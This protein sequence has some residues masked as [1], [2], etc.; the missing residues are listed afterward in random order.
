MDFTREQ[1]Q[2]IET[3]GTDILVAA[4]AG[5][6]KTRVLVNRIA[7]VVLDRDEPRDID[8]LLVVTFTR[9][10]ADEMRSRLYKLLDDKLS[11]SKDP[12]KIARIYDQQV[13]LQRSWI[14]TVHGFCKRVL[15]EN[16]AESGIDASYAV[17]DPALNDELIAQAIRDAAERFSEE[18][19]DRYKELVDIYGSFSSDEFL[20][21]YINK[22][23]TLSLSFPDPDK[24]L[25]DCLEK[26]RYPF[27]EGDFARTAYGKWLIEIIRLKLKVY[28]DELEKLHDLS[29]RYEIGNCI[30]T[31]DEDIPIMERLIEKVGRDGIT[32]HELF[33]ACSDV[34]FPRKYGATKEE[35]ENRDEYS[36]E[37]DKKIGNNRKNV[38][39]AVK[40]DIIGKLFSGSPDVPELDRLAVRDSMEAFV[41]IVR[42]ASELFARAKAE[43]HLYDYG[44]MEHM[45]LNILT[46]SAGGP[47][48]LALSY[49]KKFTEIYVDEYQDTSMIQEQILK[50][51][52]GD[53]DNGPNMFMVGDV[54]QSIYGFNNARPDLFLSKY[55]SFRNVDDPLSKNG[56]DEGVLVRL[57]KN[58]RSRNHV[59]DSVNMIFSKLMNEAT[60]GMPYGK[61]ECLD[62]GAD[63]PEQEKKEKTEIVV[64]EPADR[65]GIKVDNIVLE[66]YEILGRIKEMIARGDTVYDRDSKKARPVRYSDIC[67][68]MR[69]NKFTGKLADLLR[70]GGVPVKDTKDGSGLFVHPEIRTI[71]SFMQ[72]IDNPL[73]DIPLAAVL[74]NIYGFTGNMFVRIKLAVPGNDISLYR[75][76]Q[77]FAE[78]TDAGETR[79]LA[80]AFV[81]RLG[82]F[83]ERSAVRPVTETLRECMAENGFIDMI[84]S[85]KDGGV[86]YSNLMRL[87]SITSGFDDSGGGAFSDYILMLDTAANSGKTSSATPPESDAVSICTIHKSKGLEYPVVIIA[88]AGTGRNKKDEQVRLT[89]HR[90]L[91]FG[92]SCYVNSSRSVYCSIMNEAIRLRT[93]K[94]SRAEEMRLLYVA[95]TRAKEKLIITGV[96]KE[97]NKFKDDCYKKLDSTGKKPMDYHV[98]EADDFLT[99]LGMAVLCADGKEKESVSL[100]PGKYA[101]EYYESLI[102]AEGVTDGEESSGSE[103]EQTMGPRFGL[104]APKL[105]DAV[106]AE[107]MDAVKSKA[108]CPAK[109]SVSELKRLYEAK[110]GSGDDID[111]R[112]TVKVYENERFRLLEDIDRGGKSVSDAGGSALA[113]T[114]LH[115]C[116]EHADFGKIREIN[117]DAEKAAG[118]AAELRDELID[119]GFFSAEDGKLVS[120]DVLGKF[121]CSDFAREIGGSQEILREIPFAVSY[122][123]SELF[124]DQALEGNTTVVQGIIDCVCRTGG[125]VTLIDYKSDAVRGG[126]GGNA[127]LEEH[128]KRYAVQ[129]S[130]YSEVV[131]RAFGKYPDK[132]VLYYLRY[133]REFEISREMMTRWMR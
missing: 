28:L 112:M 86:A 72:I 38:V 99:L 69:N 123:S 3:E 129:L 1:K 12:D 52:S 54:K 49:R 78:S 108:D 93:A 89:M 46:C 96:G 119:R 10:A 17:C 33:S 77:R 100:E 120:A 102:P 48:E 13:R 71:V 44:D 21:D 113:G 19:P 23:L 95:M 107:R 14:T 67:I 58:F 50:Q 104:P 83:R 34:S 114:L 109:I 130:V 18:Q 133:G 84:R 74:K 51:I 39:D 7:R 81:S 22:A 127:D 66:G 55:M 63:Y 16:M 36:A 98:L 118:Y 101:K 132:I 4:G 41:E 26:F 32:W 2:A 30:R 105:W 35:K 76:I 106:S 131:K 97:L 90:E 75:R 61:G 15:T 87:M 116:L 128:S 6:G 64:I 65:N 11:E 31:L 85:L 57:N 111:D 122:P 42:L 20:L 60:C 121:F 70:S 68:L 43:R 59:I 91:G 25:E 125:N 62:A 8:T 73:N 82:Y 88:G 45:C 94:D 56:T 47:S 9:A 80:A 115:C 40:D 117:G 92:P 24:W 124:G 5:S 53:G 27:P 126:A 79:R 110:G 29:D 103:C 37:L